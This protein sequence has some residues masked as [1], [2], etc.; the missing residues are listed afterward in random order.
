[1]RSRR[2]FRPVVAVV[3]AMLLGFFALPVAAEEQTNLEQVPDQ[4]AVEVDGALLFRVRGTTSFPAEG[5]AA[6]IAQRIEAAALDPRVDPASVRTGTSLGLTAI[7]AGPTRIMVVS[8][9]DA[10]LEQLSI[11]ALAQANRSP[12]PLGDR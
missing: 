9:A 3:L 12:C 5:R 4:A 7:F 8:E 6:G 2:P 10:E 11:P 1:M